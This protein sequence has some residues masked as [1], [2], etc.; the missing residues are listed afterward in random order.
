MVM[1]AIKKTQMTT[2]V[3]A[4]VLLSPLLSAVH[5]EGF[6]DGVKK[7]VSGAVDVVTDTAQ[8]IDEEE[9]A[10]ETRAKIDQMEASTLKRLF[11]QNAQ[12]KTLFH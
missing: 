10:A 1:K 9:T 2:I 5:A 4:G 11:S 8:S 7:G 6:L 12:A 3:L